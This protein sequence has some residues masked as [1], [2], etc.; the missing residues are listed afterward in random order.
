[1]AGGGAA[2]SPCAALP[3]GGFSSMMRF[4]PRS[5]AV[6]LGSALAVAA[7]SPLAAVA[8]KGG[9]SGSSGKSSQGHHPSGSGSGKSAHAT[10]ST[11]HP[12]TAAGSK[13]HSGHHP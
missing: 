7:A 13:A 3:D 2:L 9:H 5:A 10:T 4:H 1:M 12:K 8:Q 11:H 6:I